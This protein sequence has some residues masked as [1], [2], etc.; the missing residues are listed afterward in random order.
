MTGFV[1]KI[2]ALFSGK[3]A[4][5]SG[6]EQAGATGAKPEL[7][8]DCRIFATP[9]REGSQ[10]RLAGRIEKD[11]NGVVLKRHFVRA[12]VFSSANE[13]VDYSQRKARLIIDQSG[14]SLF[15]D[16]APERNV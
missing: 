4:Q 6:E 8:A 16:G 10:F 3:G 5:N 9:Q 13:A 7:Y 2:L 1:S 11:V 14:P 12:D 15:D